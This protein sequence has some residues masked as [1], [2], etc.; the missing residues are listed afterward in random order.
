MI[1]RREEVFSKDSRGLDGKWRLLIR[2]PSLYRLLRIWFF[3]LSYFFLFL[4]LLRMAFGAHG[5]L[6]ED[7]ERGTYLLSS[8]AL[9]SE[10]RW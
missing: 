10:V 2:T 9:F 3:F 5:V 1:I 7:G 8:S 4:F 6:R